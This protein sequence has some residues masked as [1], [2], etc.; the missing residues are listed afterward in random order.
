LLQTFQVIGLTYGNWLSEN[1]IVKS[2]ASEE[3]R[4][5][6]QADRLTD[7]FPVEDTPWGYSQ[8]GNSLAGGQIRSDETSLCGRRSE[9]KLLSLWPKTERIRQSWEV[10]SKGI[11]IDETV[12]HFGSVDGK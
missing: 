1:G 2:P 6:D 8:T 3:D 5:V 7:E 12:G 11:R 4:R 10:K 9:A